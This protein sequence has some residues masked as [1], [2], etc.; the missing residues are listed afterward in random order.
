MVQR[1]LY[2]V[3]VLLAGLSLGVS[4]YGATNEE[5]MRT[6]MER[7]N[8]LEQKN[9]ELERR[10]N[11]TTSTN[12]A[13]DAAI[14]REE[15]TT[16]AAVNVNSDHKIKIGGYF[17]TSYQYNFNR[18]DNQNNNLRIFDTDSNGFNLHLAELTFDGLPTKP[19]E[20]GFRLDLAFGSDVR[21]F[22]PIDKYTNGG[23]RLTDFVD[24]DFKQ[25]YL[26]YIVPIGCGCGGAKKGI[27]LDFGKF[28]TWAG[29][30]TI[31]GA[32][33]INSSRSI[34]FGYAIPFTH[35]GA[36][37]TYDV[38]N[39]ECSKWTIGGAVYNGWDNVQDQ[40]RSKAFALYS[41][42]KPAKWFEMFTTGIGGG[43]ENFIDERNRFAVATN[44]LNGL[45]P[46]DPLTPGFGS[47]N[48]GST[49]A[50][51]GPL[52][53]GRDAR[54][55]DEKDGQGG[56][57][58]IDLSLV[59]KPLCGK[60]DLIIALNGDYGYQA[61]TS[62]LGSD[63]SVLPTLEQPVGHAR[64]YGG[65]AYVKW[66]FAKRWYLGLRGEYFNDPQGARTGLPQF[67]TEGTATL[68][69]SLTD[70]LHTRLEFRHDQSNR[71]VFSNRKGVT[72]LGPNLDRP[73]DRHSQNTIMYSWLYK[74]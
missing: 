69:Y 31:E 58:L 60:D 26:E 15:A 49:N 3:A 35:T 66:Q 10:A 52:D 33:N 5:M 44:A 30:E 14:A 61:R 50:L 68:D 53:G 40:N 70:N 20:A 37:A 32:D 39:S 29:Y 13:V 28:V 24:N 64:W 51:F 43:S 11:A 65:A 34:L 57:F 9:A 56:R 2:V 1:G 73:F 62:I 38:W 21:W 22:K 45:D 6:L 27:T 47:V 48:A 41:D 8:S 42:W 23:E 12:A 63:A 55:F 18:P 17:D 4:T 19:G 59:F 36:R 67:L 72:D 71:S 7:V 74:F 46:L 25:A 54:L 16:A